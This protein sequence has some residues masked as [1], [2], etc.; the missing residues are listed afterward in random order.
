MLKS[1]GLKPMV[2]GGAA[3]KKILGLLPLVMNTCSTTAISKLLPSSTI[4]LLL[5][6]QSDWKF[7]EIEEVKKM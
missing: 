1:G 7:I 5:Q 2:T 3:V 6:L 4:H